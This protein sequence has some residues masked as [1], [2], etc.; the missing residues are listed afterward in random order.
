VRKQLLTAAIGYVKL[1]RAEFLMVRC[2][3][4][5]AFPAARLLAVALSLFSSPISAQLVETNKPQ[6]PHDTPIAHVIAPPTGVLIFNL[7]SESN[8]VALDRQA[9]LKLVNL[10]DDTVTWRTTDDASEIIFKDIAAGNYEV[11]VTA[12]G[13]LTGQRLIQIASS[14][15]PTEVEIVLRRDPSWVNFEGPASMM[16]PKVRTQLKNGALLLK[17]GNLERA[18]K[19]LEQAHRSAPG[20]S[21]VN[22]LLGHLFFQKK[23]FAQAGEYLNA[24]A[25]ASPHDAQILNLLGRTNLERQDN[26]N[27]QAVLQQAINAAP[28]DWLAHDLLA[29]AY[30]RERKYEKARDEAQLAIEK[31]KRTAGPAQLVLG[32]SLFALGH[33]QD[34]IA[35]LDA[36]LSEQPQHPQAAQIRAFVASKDRGFDHLVNPSAQFP[37]YPFDPLSA[38][39]PP[40]LVIR[41]WR[42]LGID[43][44]RR[45]VTPEIGCPVS[46][47]LEESGRHAQQLVQDVSRFAA[48]EDLFHQVLD[49]F[50]IPIRTETRKY[51]YVSSISEPRAG[52]LE[53]NEIRAEKLTTAGYPDRIASTGFAA[54]ALV[55]HP[56]RRDA[57]EISCEG[58]SDWHGQAV[59]LVRFRQRSD[60]PN[61][62]H[63]YTVNNRVYPVALQGLAW[64]TADT[65]QIVRIESE[66]IRP[67]PEI[68]L[69]SEHQIVQYGPVPFAKKNITLWLPKSAE[70]YFEFRRRRYYRRHSFD[71]Y[72][73]FSVDS[74]EQRKEPELPIN[75][76]APEQ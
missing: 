37:S 74:G 35:A 62:M 34:A 58:L 54:L 8:S 56:H 48:I 9:V 76:M 1:P 10:A 75:D 31:G 72:M 24:A 29:N 13:Y 50:G 55:F 33:D 5:A 26:K 17:S 28:D 7:F 44:I 45:T 18:Q 4:R 49:D 40:E 41:S 12:V 59:W 38:L 43:E 42:P 70:I 15:P 63:S 46:R 19:Q 61:Y 3:T 39:A 21:D 64:I 20:S 66:I 67:V 53:V 14:L 65:F 57:F 2:R 69:V 23:D 36:F 16:S 27:A 6:P 25:N 71:H 22:F 68:Q 32:A 30:L 52:V 60:R 51:N 47:V 73:L 11:E